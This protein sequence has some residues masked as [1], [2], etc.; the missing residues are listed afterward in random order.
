MPFV[1]VGNKADLEEKRQV[2]YKQG[3]ELAKNIMLLFSRLV[4]YSIFIDIL[5]LYLYFYSIYSYYI[6]ILF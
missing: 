1:I 6:S 4:F 5:Y 3:K 2:S